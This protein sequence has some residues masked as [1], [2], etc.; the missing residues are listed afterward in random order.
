[1][2]IDLRMRGGR[3]LTLG[4][5]HL[6][7]PIAQIRKTP[8]ETIA[9]LDRLLE[10]HTDEATARELN[11][12]GFRNWKGEP[13]TAKRVRSTRRSYGLLSYRE[14]ERTRLRDQ[15]FTTAE[16][17][18]DQL[19]LTPGTVRALGRDRNEPRVERA[20]ISTEGR[21][22]CMFRAN[23]HDDMVSRTVGEDGKITESA[24]KTPQTEQ[25]AS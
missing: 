17:V 15:G 23:C 2:T 4:P 10:T 19:D 7:R 6:P 13:F 18:A 21:R 22:Y 5:L 12:S 14:R 20:I 11:R 1:M 9:G 25:G 3:S 8:P 16:E 24:R